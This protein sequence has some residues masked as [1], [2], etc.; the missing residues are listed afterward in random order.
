MTE[1]KD[2]RKKWPPL[3]NATNAVILTGYIFFN[4][5]LTIIGPAIGFLIYVGINNV[6]ILWFQTGISLFTIV[7]VYS[8]IWISSL[9]DG[10]KS[11]YGRRKPLLVVGYFLLVLV[12]FA[13]SFPPDPHDPSIL[14]GW[15][16]LFFPLV[17]L[18][19]A[20]TSNTLTSLLIETSA[21][22]EDYQKI[23]G[24]PGVIGMV[25][26]GVGGLTMV[27]FCTPINRLIAPTFAALGCAIFLALLFIHLPSQVNR[28]VPKQPPLIP[29]FRTCL[30][31]Q[32]FRTIFINETIVSIFNMINANVFNV[33][34]IV[35]GL[36]ST[37]K[38]LTTFMLLTTLGGGLAA[39][40]TGSFN[41][42]VTL[43]R[44]D[45]VFVYKIM[46]I[47]MIA[48]NFLGLSVTFVTSTYN[49]LVVYLWIFSAII[50]PIQQ[51][52][53]FFIRDL[54]TYDTFIT[55]LNRE[56]MYLAAMGTPSLVI[57]K[58]FSS[59]PTILLATTGYY[60]VKSDS[61]PYIVDNYHWNAYTIWQARIYGTFLCGL[62]ALWSFW[63]I[64]DYPMNNVVCTQISNA[65]KA[66]ML[67]KKEIEEEAEARGLDIDDVN[68][69][70]ILTGVGGGKK[71][72]QDPE[73][74]PSLSSS[75]SSSFLYDDS[76]VGDSNEFNRL[77]SD[78]ISKAD[79]PSFGKSI[80][81]SED[82]MTLQHF[83][84]DEIRLIARMDPKSEANAALVSIAFRA[85]FG[86]FFG[87]ATTI[88]LVTALIIQL[89]AYLTAYC[90]LLTD[91]M[92]LSSAFA[93]Y[94]G[95][96]LRATRRLNKHNNSTLIALAR[97]SLEKMSAY[98]ETLEELLTKDANA[99]SGD[100]DQENTA[101][102]AVIAAALAAGSEATSISRF[103]RN[104]WSR[105]SSSSSTSPLFASLNKN[106]VDDARQRQGAPGTG[107]AMPR[108][109]GGYA[110]SSSSSS[111]VLSEPLL[112]SAHSVNG[113]SNGN[114]NGRFS[115]KQ[116][117]RQTFFDSL[118]SYSTQ[119]IYAI[120][121]IANGFA[122]F[123]MLTKET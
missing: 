41:I 84:K 97:E 30:R 93:V 102:E 105:L 17:G 51:I 88:M 99:G 71:L 46:S 113:N 34:V 80:A 57:A 11:R 63:V 95:M 31:T 50:T 117:S 104:S 22:P 123:C 33:L 89:R 39:L 13:L 116:S 1:I 67:K 75:S 79:V 86:V 72:S 48:W 82:D 119:I 77:L 28:K 24:L 59:I 26:G 23:A 47:L 44:F 76:T 6:N 109:M 15:F 94:E 52:Q 87:S 103:L 98:R 49:D 81:D 66:S 121:F 92:L 110:G 100:S 91:L 21:S 35:G 96:R 64:K 114:G 7:S 29:S 61:S 2:S 10:L 27:Q 42:L 78:R 115:H 112:P 122:V 68:F 56:G 40:I 37:N 106:T 62:L 60:A 120:L 16:I 111:K 73:R 20:F 43:P 118:S 25:L 3:F 18:A 38:E 12:V 69:E 4:Q 54:V 8:N 83:S 101:S 9:S 107:S 55:G 108:H 36:V 32:E 45:K 53:H 19:G 70:N 74:P 5:L 14:A 90:V 65:V 85:M 58:F